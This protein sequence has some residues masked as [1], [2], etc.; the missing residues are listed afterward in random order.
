MVKIGQQET[1][2][3]AAEWTMR[4]TDEVTTLIL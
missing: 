2:I 3:V 4:D 1:M